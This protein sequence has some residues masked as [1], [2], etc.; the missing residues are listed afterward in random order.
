[1]DHRKDEVMATFVYQALNAAGKTQKGTVEAASSEDAIQ[2]IKSQG[3]FPTS[4]QPQKE[5][6]SKAG[7]KGGLAGTA[8]ATKKKKKKCNQY[9]LKSEFYYLRIFDSNKVIS[10][11]ST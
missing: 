11:I 1:M 3:Y 2:R 5:K 7:A 9:N 10:N 4:V 6:K 8:T